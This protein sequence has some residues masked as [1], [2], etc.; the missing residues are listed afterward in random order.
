AEAG[1]LV[2]V[3]HCRLPMNTFTHGVQNI[4]DSI[5]TPMFIILAKIGTAMRLLFLII[6]LIFL[7][8]LVP[9]TFLIRLFIFSHN[10]KKGGIFSLQTGVYFTELQVVSTILQIIGLLLRTQ[11]LL[12]AILGTF[13]YGITVLYTLLLQPYF[14]PLGNTVWSSLITIVFTCYFIG[15]PVAVLDTTK[16]WVT[17]IVWILFIPAVIGLPILTGWMT[18]K[19]GRS[20]WAVREDEDITGLVNNADTILLQKQSPRNQYSYQ[21]PQQ[22]QL[23][24]QQSNSITQ[25]GPNIQLQPMQAQFSASTGTTQSSQLHSNEIGQMYNNLQTQPPTGILNPQAQIVRTDGTE[26]APVIDKSF[27]PRN[28]ISVGK[29]LSLLLHNQNDITTVPDYQSV[30]APDV[31]PKTI[32]FLTSVPNNVSQSQVNDR[33]QTAKLQS[34]FAQSQKSNVNN[35]TKQTNKKQKEPKVLKKAPKLRKYKSV[36][37]VENAIK[38]LCKKEMRKKSDAIVLAEQI[39]AQGQKK[40]GTDSHLWVTI[41]L[42][43]KSFTKNNMKLGEALRSTKQNI[44]SILDRWIVYALTHDLER[45]NSQKGGSS[46]VGVAFRLRFDKGTKE[47]ELSKAYLSQAYS[48]LTRDHLD[49][50]RIMMFLDKAITHERESRIILEDLMKQYPGSVQ[51]L[52]ALGALLRDIYRDDETA[53]SMFNEATAIEEDAAQSE[54]KTEDKQSVRDKDKMSNAG[55]SQTK[56]SSGGKSSGSS[57]TRKRR[58]RRSQKGN[59]QIAQQNQKDLIPG[60]IQI[61]V[62]CMFIVIAVVIV[63]FILTLIGFSDCK[64]TVQAINTCQSMMVDFI[65]IYLFSKYLALR[66][67]CINDP[68]IEDGV[69]WIPSLERIKQIMG[70]LSVG[71]NEEQDEAYSLAKG[72]IIYDMFEGEDLMQT[73]TDVRKKESGFEVHKMWQ[74]P[75]NFI[76]LMNNAANVAMDV[77]LEYWNQEE[78]RSQQFLY[79]IRSNGPVTMVEAA[80][81]MA[82]QFARNAVK[83]STQNIII[84]AVLGVISLTIPISINLAQF[85]LTINR[86]KKERQ[87]IFLKLVKTPKHDYLLLK[88]RL[89]DVDK[90]QDETEANASLTMEKKDSTLNMDI[91]DKDKIDEDFDNLEDVEEK[92][93]EQEDEQHKDGQEDLLGGAMGMFSG[94]MSNMNMNNMTQ[95]QLMQMQMMHLQM[96]M[97]QQQKD[98]EEE[99]K[100]GEEDDDEDD[101]DEDEDDS[102]DGSDTKR[103]KK[104]KKKKNQTQKGKDN[105][106]TDDTKDDKEKEGDKDQQNKEKDL[107]DRVM[108]ISSYIPTSFYIRMIIGFAMVIIFPAVFTV[109]SIVSQLLV[110][111]Y[112]EAIFLAGYRSTVQGLCQLCVVVIVQPPTQDII[113]HFPNFKTEIATNPVWNDISHFTMHHELRVSMLDK[114]I[115]FLTTLNQIVLYGKSKYDPEALTGDSQIDELSSPRTLKKGSGT[116]QIQYEP[117][118]IFI[119]RDG[120][121]LLEHRIYS[122]NGPFNGLEALHAL[123][124]QS[125]KLIVEDSRDPNT[126]MPTLSSTAVQDMATLFIF[127]MR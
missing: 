18:Y 2:T 62:I 91:D 6:G 71:V 31:K 9:F 11:K 16:V 104:E 23:Q 101:E 50:E 37:A 54:G 112:N 68:S 12:I 86:L 29:P 49:L 113:G 93:K 106:K 121:E 22:Q 48:L 63:V 116:Q 108:K 89:D 57:G 64:T 78:E 85:M 41:A 103:K 118:E 65:D 33:Q 99:A 4:P 51:V 123:F 79:Y 34:G 80:K 35:N 40:F 36:F 84:S 56:M 74:Q 94:M 21:Q 90:D 1:S 10:H 38:F 15:I 55:R 100:E 47:H 70:E 119:H 67:E 83:S 98:K 27:S 122:I 75:I 117:T 120:D 5:T 45:E 20:L 7:V 96:K 114:A 61:V 95:Q 66:H 13:I 26:S 60:F 8:V 52:R 28:G 82:I 53:L 76:D 43:H 25:Q 124:M 72:Q 39:I 44:P 107:T 32:S 88:K 42:Y 30:S 127:D 59:L 73:L 115:T 46:S 105:K 77:S 109:L 102:D 3:Q 69:E 92:E 14:H 58:K 87:A 17:V 81:R 126:P 19:R 110:I 111:E 97:Q 24:Q 125:A